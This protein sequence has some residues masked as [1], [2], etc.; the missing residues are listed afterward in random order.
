MSCIDP[1][2]VASPGVRGKLLMKQAKM[3]LFSTRAGALNQASKLAHGRL[4]GILREIPQLL[5]AGQSEQFSRDD[6][7]CA[8]SGQRAKHDC[9]RV[10]GFTLRLS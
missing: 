2:F 3:L 6:C 10:D 8:C 9:H 1:L 4:Q 5:R 7:A